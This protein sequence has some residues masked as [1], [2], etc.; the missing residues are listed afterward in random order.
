MRR[1]LKNKLMDMIDI[2]HQAHHEIN[3]YI[4]LEQYALAQSLL[5]Q[6]Q[7]CALAIGTAIEDVEGEGFVT[8]SYIEE[9][10]EALYHIYEELCKHP[11][12]NS[13]QIL[14]LLNKYVLMVES[15]I[16]HDIVLKKEI[17]FLPYKA[18]MW[19]SLESVW[20]AAEEDPECV[21]YVIPIPYYDKNPDGSLR[22]EHYEGNSFPEDV[23]I[24]H[25]SN[26]DFKQRHPDAIF[27]HNP[28]DQYNYVTTVH[29]YFYTNKLK[30]FTDKLIYIPYYVSAETSPYNYEAMKDREGYILSNGVLNSDIVIVQSENTKKLFVNILEKNI[31]GIDRGYWENKIWGLGSPKLDRVNNTHRD[32]SKLP[33]SWRKNIYTSDEKRK[34]TIFYNISVGTLLNNPC[35]LKKIKDTLSFFQKNKDICLWWRP[36]PLYE[37]TLASMRPELLNQY[38][39]IVC[40]YKEEGWGI[41]DEGVDLDW[42]IAETDAYYGDSSSVVNLYKNVQKPILLQNVLVKTFYEFKT[43][44]IPIWPSTFFSDEENIWFVHGKI[45]VLLRYSLANKNTSIISVVPDEKIIHESL[46]RNGKIKFF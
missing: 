4:E 28:Y 2:L 11:N 29:P 18:S 43:K 12:A 9:Y 30:E 23:P 46:Y 14:K 5:N 35:M 22:N 45:N 20:K 27:I 13:E 24:I 39:K 42:A 36:H 37:S 40:K 38:R 17:V 25:Y 8:V 19:D 31:P 26:Y 32:D 10:C 34:K 44:D 21:A 1:S 16:K 6:C 41:F 7:E 3:A 33:E 15:S